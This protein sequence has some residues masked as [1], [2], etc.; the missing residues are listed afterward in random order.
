MR[1]ELTKIN[2]T[3]FV[4]VVVLCM[5]IMLGV[6]LLGF[7]H[8]ALANLRAVDDFRKS[9]QALNCARAGLNIAIAAI[10]NTDDIHTNRTLLNL[11]SGESAFDVGDGMCSIT[12]TE[13]NGKLNMNLLKD[14]TGNL[15][16]SRIE[17]LLRLIDLTNQEHA[18][19]SNI[20]YGLVPSIID[21]TDNDDGVT[22]LPF[23]NY[24]NFGAESSYYDKLEPPYRCKNTLF[25]ITEELLLVKGVTP[26]VYERICDYITVY[27]KGEININCA[28][29]RVIESL[30]EKIDPA[31]AQ[32]IIDRREIKPFESITELQ[33]VPGMTD[34]IYYAIKKTATVSPTERY[35]YVTSRGNVDRLNCEIVA[36][37]KRNMK[38]EN[39]EVILYKEL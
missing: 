6:L 11:F 2:R 17:Q 19:N 7:N 39:V 21:W 38:T 34:D 37:L 8:K 24:E 33:D 18:G 1:L 27:G 36:I 22:Y 9:E 10:R 31:L 30:S 28:S 13:E 5:V 15:D 23:I 4:V 12:I 20:G 25:D 26:Q 29:K 32:L 16:Q 14:K 35:Y 3:G